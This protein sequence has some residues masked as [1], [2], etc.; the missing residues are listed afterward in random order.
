MVQG[1]P[2][3]ALRP[4]IREY[5]GW[6]ERMASPLCRRELPTEVIPVIRRS[7]VKCWASQMILP[8]LLIVCWSLELAP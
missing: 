4:Y 7:G 8:A 1:E 5:V 3:L 6:F 2:P